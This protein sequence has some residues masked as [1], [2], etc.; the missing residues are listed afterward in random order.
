LGSR[1][2]LDE[3]GLDSSCEVRGAASVSL[4]PFT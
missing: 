1:L 3:R 2:D 4:S